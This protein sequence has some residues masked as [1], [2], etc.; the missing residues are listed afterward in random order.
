MKPFFRNKRLKAVTALS[1]ALILSLSAVALTS[2]DEEETSPDKTTTKTDN[3]AIANGNFEFFSDDDL[4]KLIVSPSGWSKSN[5]QD[6]FGNSANSSSKTHGSG[7]ID[8]DADTWKSLTTATG[9]KIDIEKYK[10]SS[11]DYY[12]VKK[13]M[14]DAEKVW[15]DMSINDRLAFYDDIDGKFSAYNTAKDD[16]LS[17]SDFEYYSDYTYSIDADDVPDCENPGVHEGAKEGET[18]VLMIS[19]HYPS[20]GA[21]TG[22]AQKYT[23]STT[24]SLEPGTAAELTMYVKTADLTYSNGTPVTAN[25]GAYIGITHTA[26]STTLEQMQIKNI[27]TE[28]MTEGKDA[29]GWVKYTVYVKACSYASSSVT[30]VLGLGQGS[31]Q[32]TFE[33]VEGYA[34]FDDVDVKIVDPATLPAV[35]DAFT[36]TIATDSNRL[37]ATDTTDYAAQTSYLLD[38]STEGE[39]DLFANGSSSQVL[40]GNVTANTALTETEGKNGKVFTTDTLKDGGID[41]TNDFTGFTSWQALSETYQNNPYLNAVWEKDFTLEEGY[42]L[43]FGA[44]EDMLLLLSGHGA[45]YTTTMESPLFTIP[46]GEY[47]L[48]SFWVKTSAMGSYTGA[49]VTLTETNTETVTTLGSIDSTVLAP[50][51]LDDKE[52]IYSGWT[53]CF[54][55][56]HNDSVNEEALSFTLK[57]SYG[58]TTIGETDSKYSYSEGYAAYAGFRF[59]EIDKSQFG[60]AGTAGQSATA[61]LTGYTES[62]SKGFASTTNTDAEKIEKDLAN[63]SGYKGVY[64]GT[65]YNVPG[66]NDNEELNSNKNAGLL[67]K[68]YVDA[69]VAENHDWVK[70][71]SGQTSVT[72]AMAFWSEHFGSTTQPL[73]I[74]NVVEQSYGF[75]GTT[76]NLSQSGYNA[77]SVRVRVSTGAKAYIYLVDT[78]DI[79]N[80]YE[81]TQS[82]T[83]VNVTYWYDDN[84]NICDKDPSDKD[85]TK[86]NAVFLMTDY[87]WLVINEN[88]NWFRSLSAADQAKYKGAKF[89]NMANYDTDAN[90]NLLV[91]TK[92]GLPVVSYDYAD[93]YYDDGI[94]Y[95]AQGGKFYA[96]SDHTTEVLPIPA[97]FTQ[98]CARYV[99]QAYA[100]ERSW[101]LGENV[102][103][104]CANKVETYFVVDGTD[105]EVANKWVTVNFFIHT[106]DQS[107]PY[108]LELFSGSRD[109]SVKNPAG[110]YVMFDGCN[111]SNIADN[112]DG[113]LSDAIEAKGLS[114]NSNGK[115][116]DA[117]GTLYNEVEYYTYT[118]FDDPDFQRYDLSLD[119]NEVGN[120]YVGYEQS[121]YSE[122]ITYFRSEEKVSESEWTYS[123][124]LNYSPMDQTVEADTIEED[125][126]EDEDNDWLT[127]PNFWMMLSS[128]I[129][130]VVLILVLIVIATIRIV[131][132][133]RRKKDVKENN[134]YQNKRMHY[135]RKL[136]LQTEEEEEESAPETAETEN[137]DPYED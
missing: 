1:A 34:F 119:E 5:G 129:L 10:V 55:F 43:P 70:T 89:A 60:Y 46:H 78:S 31:S 135:I 36:T 27:N 7:I 113:L 57:F 110:T 107:F 90:G 115:L 41:K 24:V 76:Q 96:Y 84:G 69:Y 95:Y 82:M 53:Q 125:T 74:A 97:E 80:G 66:E 127:D 48:L 14:E 37:Y 121:A 98:N 30:V 54:F 26:G 118:F 33:Y 11:G 134:N 39:D 58:N 18:G 28:Q 3:C 38:L 130:A 62:S 112:Y 4:L 52:D 15:K 63:P 49:T 29:N 67:N 91:N 44:T 132:N 13:A 56:I 116:I 111:S 120:S 136:N 106:G 32:N 92:N 72:D 77:V 17:L 100:E 51:D 94:A 65:V 61:M 68:K 16:N 35:D 117:D 109:G 40:G 83:T 81:N 128:I 25:R 6:K 102:T 50:V 2:C 99:K 124:F 133:I 45:A 123:M 64:G 101:T 108:R 122:E 79:F 22:T 131:R 8:T 42:S 103:V 93:E 87:N 12:D 126:T 75:F 85:F 86:Q 23:S 59:I 20:T 137:K 104:T 21:T 19:N 88:S 9:K 105:P 114:Y 73:L 71:V 47:K